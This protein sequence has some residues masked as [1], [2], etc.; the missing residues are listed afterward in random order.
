MVCSYIYFD[1]LELV[2]VNKDVELCCGGIVYA[3][4]NYV[5]IGI[6]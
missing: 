3:V 4:T 5:M 6:A 2:F 1:G